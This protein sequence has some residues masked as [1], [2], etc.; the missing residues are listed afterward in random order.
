MVLAVLG[1]GW[2]DRLTLLRSGQV[3]KE[4]SAT[5][6]K[7]AGAWS[8]GSHTAAKPSLAVTCECVGLRTEA[9][10]HRCQPPVGPAWETVAGRHRANPRKTDL[11]CTRGLDAWGQA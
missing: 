7:V 2:C 9:P 11:L 10:K 8:S 5:P 1:G 6:W 3:A 4:K